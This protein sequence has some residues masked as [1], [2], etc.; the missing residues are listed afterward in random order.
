MENKIDCTLVADRKR[1]DFLPNYFGGAFLVF[2]MAVYRMADEVCPN[3]RGGIWDFY[4]LG[5]GGAFIAPQFDHPVSMYVEGNGFSAEIP[6]QAAGIVL[7]LM[8]LSHL[9][10]RFPEVHLFSD[11]FHQLRDF[12][13]NHHDAALIFA[14]ID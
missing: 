11:R 13:G 5:N 7:T 14:A 2:E 12:A 10:F 1:L 9:S 4:E 6:P 3:Y 8:T